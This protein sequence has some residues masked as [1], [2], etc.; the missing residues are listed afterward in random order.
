MTVREKAERYDKL[1]SILSDGAE[2]TLADFGGAL[3][4]AQEGSWVFEDLQDEQPAPYTASEAV[5]IAMT[6]MDQHYCNILE[7]LGV[8]LPT[9]TDCDTLTLRYETLVGRKLSG[10]VEWRGMARRRKKGE[11]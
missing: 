5:I 2:T 4:L 6:Q 1:I 9:P 10:D 11:A 7:F 3:I 8:R